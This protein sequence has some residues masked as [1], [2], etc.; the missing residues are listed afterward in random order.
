MKEKGGWQPGDLS[1]RKGQKRQ[2]SN[3]EMFCKEGIAIEKFSLEKMWFE[4]LNTSE[5]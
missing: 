4:V 5:C 3:N 2:W 1:L